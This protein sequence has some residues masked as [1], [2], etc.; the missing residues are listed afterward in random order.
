MT[1]SGSTVAPPDSASTT[2][3]AIR[4]LSGTPRS[5][6]VVLRIAVSI[7]LPTPAGSLTCRTTDPSSATVVQ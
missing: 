5:G 7:A 6:W 2:R 4:A 3:S 1:S